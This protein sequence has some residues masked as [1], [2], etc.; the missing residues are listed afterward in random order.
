MV[1][2]SSSIMPPLIWHNNHNKR[3]DVHLIKGLIWH[4]E[5]DLKLISNR[6]DLTLGPINLSN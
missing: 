3:R 4:L 2:L 5:V 1:V 6:K